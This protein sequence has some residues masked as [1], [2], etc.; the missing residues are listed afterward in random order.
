MPSSEGCAPSHVEKWIFISYRREDTKYPAGRLND[1]LGQQFGPDRVFYDLA[2]APGAKYVEAIDDALR[3]TKV[4]LALIGERWIDI[5]DEHGG[6]RLDNPHDLVAREIGTALERGLLVVPVLVDG[7]RMPGRDELPERLKPLVSRNAA[8]L[9]HATFSADVGKLIGA[10][11]EHAPEADW[12]PV[13]VRHP[14]EPADAR[15]RRRG[16]GVATYLVLGFA[17]IALVVAVVATVF[18]W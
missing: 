18:S 7:A 17:I 10:I 11:V 16:M 2:T 12:W 14:V 8:R 3:T 13:P 15:A 1:L 6:R 5:T 9:E 4:L